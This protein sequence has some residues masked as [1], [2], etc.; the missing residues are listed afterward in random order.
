LLGYK[1]DAARLK[2]VMKLLEEAGEPVQHVFPADSR[3]AE[4]AVRRAL[5]LT[6]INPEGEFASGVYSFLAKL[7]QLPSPKEEAGFLRNLLFRWTGSA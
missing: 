5:P 2:E 6:A 3:Y 7:L 4:E 1:G